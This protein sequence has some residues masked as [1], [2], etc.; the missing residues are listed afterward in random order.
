MVQWAN[1]TVIRSDHEETLSMQLERL[2]DT[3]FK[4]ILVD[5][6]GSLSPEYQRAK[7]IM[8]ESVVLVNGHHQFKLPFRQYHR[9][10]LTI[11]INTRQYQYIS[12][13]RILKASPR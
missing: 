3:K 8:D 4:D 5:G 9:V 6:E 7:Q 11:S 10:F 1:L 2:Y 13:G 12:A